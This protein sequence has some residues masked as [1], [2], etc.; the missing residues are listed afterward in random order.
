MFT[1]N[2]VRSKAAGIK[3]RVD[4]HHAALDAL[5]DGPEKEAALATFTSLHLG[6]NWLA[7]KAA[8]VFDDDIETFSGGDDRPDEEP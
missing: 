6:L 8:E 3:T 4:A 5:P 2:F 1:K 7:R